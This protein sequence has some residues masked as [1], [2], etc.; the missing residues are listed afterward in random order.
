[1]TTLNQVFAYTIYVGIIYTIHFYTPYIGIKTIYRSILFAITDIKSN[2]VIRKSHNPINMGALITANIN[3]DDK[4]IRA[5]YYIL[6]VHSAPVFTRANKV[7]ELSFDF[8]LQ[9]IYF[10][11]HRNFVCLS[12]KQKFFYVIS[13]YPEVINPNCFFILFI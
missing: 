9:I 4:R 1:M 3:N 8:N 13:K 7:T 2:V 11:E 10:L 6:A 12:S 5:I